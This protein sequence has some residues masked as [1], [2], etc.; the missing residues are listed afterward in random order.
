MV[1]C[2]VN[3]DHLAEEQPNEEQDDDIETEAEKE[4]NVRTDIILKLLL[5]LIYWL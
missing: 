5:P 4:N 3:D 1:N 2:G